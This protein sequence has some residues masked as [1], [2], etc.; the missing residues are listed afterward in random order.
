MTQPDPATDPADDLDPTPQPDPAPVVEEPP[1]GNAEAARYRV[2]LRETETERD[3]LAGRLDT[4]R[5]RECHHAVAD[6][7][8]EPTDLWELGRADPNSFY[9]DTDDLDVDQLR[10]AAET[11]LAQRPRLAKATPAPPKQWGQHGATPQG[12]GANWGDVM[13]SV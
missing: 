4:M 1:S 5:R 10:Q 12:S 7:L 6:L 11:L 2:R 8:E 13:K 9:N 3:T